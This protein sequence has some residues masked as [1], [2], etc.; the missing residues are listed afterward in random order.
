MADSDNRDLIGSDAEYNAMVSYSKS[1]VA[2]PLPGECFDI[3]LTGRRICGQGV[4]DAN[5]DF[6]VDCP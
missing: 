1:K 3:A 6:A 4:K 5:S 2:L